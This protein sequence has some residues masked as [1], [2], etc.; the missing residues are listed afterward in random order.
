MSEYVRVAPIAGALGA[1][2]GGIDLAKPIGSD[3]FEALHQAV[4]D[5]KAIFFRDQTLSPEQ[6]IRFARMF[7][8]PMEDTFVQEHKDYP[9]LMELLREADD[10]GYNFG[11][12]WHS[13]STYREEPP[14][15]VVLYARELPPFGGDT[16][17]ANMELVY[18]QLSPGMQALLRTLE[19]EHVAEGFKQKMALKKGDYTKS[20]KKEDVVEINVK[21]PAVRV[22]PI[23]GRKCL[24]INEA[25]AYRFAGMTVDESQPIIQYLCRFAT[26]PQFT[27]RFRWQP[28]SLAVWD[29]RN[30]MHFAI[31]DYQGHRRLMHR[32]TVQGDKPLGVGASHVNIR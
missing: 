32:Y 26:Q 4:L 6:H 24:F 29:N 30:T 25:Y 28:G 8:E 21:H 2:V 15:G 9:E 3:V 1:E 20:F 17:W 31:N 22:H 10:S 7:G 14:M 5:Y 23:T 11:G 27:C 18:E 16:L 12:T 13:D 19:V